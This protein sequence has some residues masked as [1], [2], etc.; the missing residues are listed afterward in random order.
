MEKINEIFKKGTLAWYDATFKI[1]EIDEV[2]KPSALKAAEKALRL[3]DDY[4]W[5][6]RA[7]GVP[8][9]ML[10][11][12]HLLECCNNPRG[13]LHNGELI[14]GTNKMTSLIPKG[15]GPFKTF[16][17]SII[18]AVGTQPLLH[19]VKPEQWSTAMI[20]KQC[21]LFNGRGYLKYHSRENTPYLW[22]RTNINDGTGKYVADGKWLENAPT[23]GQ[24]GVA[25]ML[26][27]LNEMKKVTL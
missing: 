4:K 14:V 9:T 8:W 3:E 19:T 25:A 11:C 10:L 18:D 16:R 27:T 23:D 12:V 17:D 13:V 6:E 1:C 24:L 7:T 2:W 21:E 22:S 26:I 5:G 20:L 15:R